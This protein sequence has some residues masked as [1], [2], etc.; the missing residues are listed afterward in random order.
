MQWIKSNL[1]KESD[2]R[3]LLL[4]TF[5]NIIFSVGALYMVWHFIAT[6]FWPR[7][8]SPQLW[9]V[10]ISMAVVVGLAASVMNRNY[11]AAQGIWQFG[12]SFVIIL[13]YSLFQAQE[14]LIPLVFMPLMAIMTLGLVGTV[15]VEINILIV[16]ILIQ[17]LDFLPPLSY[18]YSIGVIM[19]SI[20]TGL[21][22]WG[23]SNNLLSALNSASHHYNR[24]RNLL[25]ETRHH[26]GEVSRILKERNQANYQLE[27]LNQMLQFA[28][29][30]AE[31][32]RDE[33]C[34]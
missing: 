27:R 20:F 21:L 28:R 11:L 16:V 8:F 18:G 25:E 22:G 29:S 3:D 32:A 15:L 1:E 31:E 10:T 7:V 33:P 6:L 12:L 24:A 34:K 5:R 17:N 19:G 13:A 30:K 4:N 26:R 14:I 2:S 9:W 23:M